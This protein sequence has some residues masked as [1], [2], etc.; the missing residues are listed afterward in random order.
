MKQKHANM[1]TKAEK[2]KLLPD[3]MIGYKNQTIVGWQLT[4]DR[5]E[6][7]FNAASRFSSYSIGIGIPIFAKAQHARIEAAMVNEA[8]AKA[9]TTTV[10][11]QLQ[12]TLQKYLQ[13][14]YKH[15]SAV[16]YYQNRGLKQAEV[17]L[18]TASLQY[19]TGAISYI[20]W[21]TLLAQ[22][23]TLKNEYLSA[24]YNTQLAVSEIHYLIY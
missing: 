21:S 12:T 23:I 1:Q 18:S 4:K 20:E 5:V 8:T 9:V 10:Q 6:N 24:L 14:Y 17:L 16:E 3:L 11:S 2:A 15:L 19:K 13:L 22:A 7:Y